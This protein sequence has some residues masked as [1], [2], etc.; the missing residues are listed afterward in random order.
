MRRG[1][2]NGALLLAAVLAGGGAGEALYRSDGVRSALGQMLGRGEFLNVARGHAIYARDLFQKG[3]GRAETMWI[4][5]SLRDSPRG[6]KIE[7]EAVQRE[8]DLLR[9]Q[10]GDERTYLAAL[11]SSQISEPTLR[12]MVG[13]QLETQLWIEDRIAPSLQVTEEE[14]RQA[15]AA[16][17]TRF[18]WPRRFR[19]SHIFIAAPDGTPPE[20]ILEKRRLAQGLGVRLLAGESFAELAAEASEDEATKLAGG[21]LGF[22]SDWRMPPD[23]MAELAKRKPGEV[24]SPFQ[25]Q[26]GFH[27]V[28]LMETRPAQPL[29]FEEADGEIASELAGAKRKSAVAEL[30]VGARNPARTRPAP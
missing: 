27:I 11:Q 8:M 28:R 10:F 26:L 29:T 22:F 5:K 3:D 20:V 13:D 2:R 21:D 19:A 24:S 30:V 4:A 12:T 17:G 18:E 16:G 25:S 23:F 1:I 15:Y 7:A 14:R 6:S 9:A